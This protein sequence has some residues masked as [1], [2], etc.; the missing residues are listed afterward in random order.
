MVTKKLTKSGTKVTLTTHTPG[1]RAIKIPG[2][3]VFSLLNY[4][5][6]S[7]T[8]RLVRP[9][10]SNVIIRKANAKENLEESICLTIMKTKA[11]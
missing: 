2:F 8:M 7:E 10:I 1:L 9:S 11:K 3:R 6:E 5:S 4:E